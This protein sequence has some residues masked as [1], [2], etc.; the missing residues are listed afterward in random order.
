MPVTPVYF[1]PDIDTAWEANPGA[2]EVI[3][4]FAPL[5][6]G[7]YG[8][9]GTANYYT[10][11]T[12]TGSNIVA[13]YMFR[14][15]AGTVRFLVFRSQDIDEYDNAATRTNRA[16]G[17]TVTTEWNA[18]A[19]GD[20]IIAVSLANA[21]QS[22]T[23]AG[24]T[25]LSGA[26]KARHVASNLSFVMLAD[27]D[28]GS[29]VVYKDAVYWCALQNPASWT[30]SIATQ[31]GYQRLLDTPGPITALV[32]Y[33]DQFVAFK[34]NAIFVGD[35]VGPQQFIF[36]WRCVSQKIGCVGPKAVC[37]LDGKLYFLHTSGFYE[38]DGQTIRNVGLPCAKS[39]LSESNFA[40]TDNNTGSEIRPP[41][42]GT[43]SNPGLATTQAWAD[44]VEGVVWFRGYYSDHVVLNNT[45]T[46]TMF[47]YGYNPRS[48][49]WGRHKVDTTGAVQNAV[50]N[51]S[52]VFVRASNSEIQSFKANSAARVLMVWN[53]DAGTKVRAVKYPAATTDSTAAS[54]T[55][56]IFGQYDRSIFTGKI[57][58]RHVRGSD[59]FSISDGQ[60]GSIATTI[61][62]YKDEAQTAQT[63]TAAMYANIELQQV[64]SNLDGRFKKVTVGYSLGLTHILG[65]VAP[66]F[67][68]P[69]GLR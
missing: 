65:G 19:W 68:K 61:T 37:E 29:S 64:Q 26:P 69:T 9:I 46:F 42:F 53:D 21:T 55:T 17:L 18:A 2:L 30:P 60:N 40:T 57:Y 8:T 50:T 32:A 22:S 59:I 3:N 44:E 47:M 20:Q 1:A 23:G 48:Q 25:A 63:G 28:D 33:R 15:V 34:D 24:F 66:Q 6:S 45:D 36:Q 41:N 27:V 7:Y 5:Q 58:L 13:A 54:Y 52:Q 35:Y 38:F 4:A 10:S 12:L 67:D 16:T 43:Y 11:S 39:Y 51:G 56:G 14:K 49:K 31:A 62:S